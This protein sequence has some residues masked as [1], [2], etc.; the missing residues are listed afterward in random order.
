MDE[1]NPKGDEQII[2][3]C[4]GVTKGEIKDAIKNGAKSIEAVGDETGAGTVCG[5]C[6]RKIQMLIDEYKKD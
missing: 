4:M 1:L 3:F 6:R 5:T 2:C